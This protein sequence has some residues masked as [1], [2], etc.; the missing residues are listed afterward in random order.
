MGASYFGRIATGNTELVTRLRA[1]GR[2]WPDT[3]AKVRAFIRAER[4]KR[5]TA[6]TKGKAA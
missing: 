4:R 6:P 3:E 2:V 1:G 5:G